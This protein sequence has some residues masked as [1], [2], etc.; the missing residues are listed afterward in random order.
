MKVT[1]RA[2]LRYCGALSTWQ[3]RCPL[4]NYPVPYSVHVHQHH[5]PYSVAVLTVLYITY[6]RCTNNHNWVWVKWWN[7]S[8]SYKCLVTSPGSRKTVFTQIPVQC[9]FCIHLQCSPQFKK[10]VSLTLLMQ[11][12]WSR[13]QS[14]LSEACLPQWRVEIESNL[15]WPIVFLYGFLI[16]SLFGASLLKFVLF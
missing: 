6:V 10:A 7:L 9:V 15:S 5:N 1:N 12:L 4:D 16:L 11:N 3:S 8:Y 2:G 13:H 14:Q